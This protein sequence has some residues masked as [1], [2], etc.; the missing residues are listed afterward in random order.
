MDRVPQ[1]SIRRW[2]RHSLVLLLLLLSPVGAP[3]VGAALLAACDIPF[4]GVYRCLVPHPVLDYFLAFQF[5]PWMWGPL[6]GCVWIALSFG[7]AFAL[8]GHV[9]HGIWEVT[10][11]QL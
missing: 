5:L 7:I 10:M 8:I 1:E 4:E 9:L 3:L 11:E 6:L 2:L